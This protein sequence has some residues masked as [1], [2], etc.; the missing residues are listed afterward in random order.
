[1]V[2]EKVVLVLKLF[3][4]LLYIRPREYTCAPE[5]R[6]CAVW[7]A[8]LRAAGNQKISNAHLLLRNHVAP[9]TFG[10][11]WSTSRTPLAAMRLRSVG[12]SS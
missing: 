5:A 12:I 10:L 4:Y 8:V 3:I 7:W 11:R 6:A 2:L 1:M 9:E